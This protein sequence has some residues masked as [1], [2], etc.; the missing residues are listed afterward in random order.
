MDSSQPGINQRFLDNQ[1]IEGSIGEM[2]E[3]SLR[4]IERSTRVQSSA[5]KG[6]G[7]MNTLRPLSG[8]PW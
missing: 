8:R 6:G 5:L 7:R 4:F 2:P 3:E 1:R